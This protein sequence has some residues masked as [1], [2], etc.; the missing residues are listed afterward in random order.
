MYFYF[1]VFPKKII[2]IQECSTNIEIMKTNGIDH[3]Q[4]MEHAEIYYILDV[5]DKHAH[6]S[7]IRKMLHNITSTD[8]TWPSF[9]R[10]D[11]RF[12]EALCIKVSLWT[13]RITRDTHL[14]L[15]SAPG[16]DKLSASRPAALPPG[17]E[18]PVPIEKDPGWLPVPRGG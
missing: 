11:F 10:Y 9:E 18:T 7:N 16:W 12:K 4:R 17:N 15:S 5:I 8:L 14:F 13:W 6:I 2:F 1:G 3:H